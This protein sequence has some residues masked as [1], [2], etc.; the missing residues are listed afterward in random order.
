MKIEALCHIPK[1]NYGYAYKEKE[2]HIRFR[3]AKNDIDK[4]EIIYGFKYQWE[5]NKKNEMK[6]ILSD[7][8]FDYYQFNIVEEDSRIGYYFKLTKGEK[9]IY[10][11]EAGIVDKF[12]DEL[13]YCYYFQYP[14]INPI[15]VHKVPSWISETVFYQIF[16]ERFFNGDVKNS[17]ENLSNW[18]DMPKPHSFFGGDLRGIIE[19]L[20]YLKELGVNGIYLTPIFK[21]PSNHKYDTV[22]Y[23]E[24]DPFFGDESTLKELVERSHE[25]G[26]KI[27]LDAVFNHCSNQFPPFLDV[28]EKGKESRYFDWFFINDDLVKTDPPNYKMFGSVGCMPKLN[29]SNAEVKYYLLS[30]IRYWTENFRIDGWRLDV[31]DE[32]D[33]HFWREF[34]VCV[35]EMDTEVIVIGEN[36]HN[37]Y[38]WLMGDQFDSVMNYPVTKL[39]LDY[40]ARRLINAKQFEYSLSSLL[41]RYSDQ[42]NEAMLNLLD[43]HDTERFLYTCGERKEYLKL[44]A[45]FLFS[46][47]GMPCTYYG[48]EIGMTGC[49]DP[50]CRKG[51][52]WNEEKWDKELLDY[53]KKLITL[54]KEEKAL[55]YGNIS[56]L[57]TDSVFIM[58]RTFKNETIMILINTTDKEAGYCLK[59]ADKKSV[60]ELLNGSSWNMA[61]QSTICI[62]E[63]TAYYLK[64]V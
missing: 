64:L 51:F 26:I 12:N 17:P 44:A 10:Y 39:C 57:S 9:F 18:D 36:W 22:N 46:Y 37:A 30:A 42:V 11:T 24:I 52:E 4:V 27:V 19:K 32:I 58:K 33:H 35:K 63:L 34:R 6:K 50:G 48:T 5:N 62:P 41:I 7:E 1:S 31:S 28:M 53:Y 3:T 29:T 23:Y 43:S 25:L 56:F 54:R 16:V 49:Y 40:F 20:D 59:E 47:K 21:S 13:A 61:E 14:Y 45:A 15:D 60:T 8:Y 38:P 55:K 2:L